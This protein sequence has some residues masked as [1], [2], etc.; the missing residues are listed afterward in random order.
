MPIPPNWLG[1]AAFGLLG[2]VNPGFWLIGAG[3]EV[4]YLAG[5]VSSARFRR[6]ANAIGVAEESR[7]SE[8]RLGRAMDRLSPAESSRFLALDERCRLA[9]GDESRMGHE[10]HGV[11]RESLARLRWAYI[12]LLTMRRAVAGVIENE[13]GGVSDRRS[14]PEQIASIE[15]RLGDPGLGTDV[16]RSL[17][18]Q[19]DVLT[20][21]VEARREARERLEQVDAELGRIEAH[22]ELLREQS[23]LAAGPE[24]A[25]ARVDA[26]A[27]SVRGT[28][29]WIRQHQTIEL[30]F[31]DELDAAPPMETR[32]A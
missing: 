27:T 20:A 11:L 4:A 12:H 18:S 16:R 15:S 23:L 21:R 28:A 30:E 32:P 17:E 10:W 22:V 13:T 8:E 3:L 26:V 1:L 9:I 6:V 7:R 25:A 19:R 29:R 31:E 5:C 24:A 14:L 2:L